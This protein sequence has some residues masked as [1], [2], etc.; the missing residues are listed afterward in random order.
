MECK[1]VEFAHHF[2]RRFFFY[3]RCKMF[4]DVSNF[5]IRLLTAKAADRIKKAEAEAGTREKEGLETWRCQ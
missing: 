1:S 4:Q 5:T 3:E 2:L